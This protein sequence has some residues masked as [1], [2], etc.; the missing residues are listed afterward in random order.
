MVGARVPLGMPL[1]VHPSRALCSKE[2][3]LLVVPG[4][5]NIHLSSTKV[6]TFLTLELAW[7][8]TLPSDI[9]ALWNA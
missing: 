5:K 8:N 6:R 3:N 7:W 4:L 2:Q 1:L 9:H